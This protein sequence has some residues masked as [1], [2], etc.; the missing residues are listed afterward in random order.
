MMTRLEEELQTN[1]NV[2]VINTNLLNELDF[3][4]LEVEESGS[5]F[6]NII[7]IKGEIYPLPK[8]GDFLSIKKLYFNYD[9]L[10]VFRLFVKAEICLSSTNNV[11]SDNNEIFDF[12]YMKIYESIKNICSIK[13]ILHSNLFKLDSKD[14]G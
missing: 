14:K 7:L 3:V 9:N 8:K 12:S 11:I 6:R 1:F 5:I 2:R 4:E 13:E 10:L